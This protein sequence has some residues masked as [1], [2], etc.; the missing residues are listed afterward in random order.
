[1][2][3]VIKKI[4]KSEKKYIY[5]IE[6]RQRGNRALQKGDGLFISLEAFAVS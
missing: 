2:F 6:K 5:K 1:M 3:S 4:K